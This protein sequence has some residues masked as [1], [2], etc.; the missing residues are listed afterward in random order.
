EIE[1]GTEWASKGYVELNMKIEIGHS[2]GPIFDRQGR[3]IGLLFGY[4][5]GDGK[6]ADPRI[7]YAV[8]S[9]NIAAFLRSALPR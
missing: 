8:P 5:L 6:T 3:V 7:A 2:G 4:E 1:H 9:N